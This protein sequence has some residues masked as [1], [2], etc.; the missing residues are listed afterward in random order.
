MAVQEIILGYGKFFIDEQ[1]IALT[2][3]GGQFTVEREYRIIEAD[4]MKAAGKDMIVIDREQPK[5]T[6]NALSIF[7]D[8][9]LT[10]YYPAMKSEEVTPDAGGTGIKITATDELVVSNNESTG[11]YHTVK[12]VGKTNKGKGVIIEIEDAVNLENIDWS[13]ID[14]DEVLQTLTYTGT[15]DLDVKQA[16]YSVTF[17]TTD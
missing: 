17:V 12:W 6:V 8:A 9:D 3:G 16:K 13:L 7:V 4:G 1:E 2:R 11:D 15:A 14:K 10:K 5:L